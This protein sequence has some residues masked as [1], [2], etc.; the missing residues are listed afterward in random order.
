[1]TLG[2]FMKLWDSNILRWNSS[3]ILVSGL[4]NRR[5]DIRIWKSSEEIVVIVDTKRRTKAGDLIIWEVIWCGFCDLKMDLLQPHAVSLK[6]LESVA[7]LYGGLFFIM[8]EQALEKLSAPWK[9][10][11]SGVHAWYIYNFITPKF[12][13]CEIQVIREE[14]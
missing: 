10:G 8:A 9:V 13:S 4:S 5:G 3:D 2:D 7:A 11:Q 1:M 14:I 6:M 12:G